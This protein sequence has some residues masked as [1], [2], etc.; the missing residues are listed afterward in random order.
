MDDKKLMIDPVATMNFF[1]SIFLLFAMLTMYSD[2]RAQ[3]LIKTGVPSD[4][5]PVNRILDINPRFSQSMDDTVWEFSGICKVLKVSKYVKGNSLST[6]AK[7]KARLTVH[8]NIFYDFFYR[9]YADTPFYQ[10]DFR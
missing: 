5:L 1:R 4:T 9:S 7:N 10:K 3:Q 8:G 6:P 2:T